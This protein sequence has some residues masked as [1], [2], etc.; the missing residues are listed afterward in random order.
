MQNCRKYDF[1]NLEFDS[2]VLSHL[3]IM[4]DAIQAV[5][6]N[7][8]W[9]KDH[10]CEKAT[11]HVE[12]VF[13]YEFYHQW[14]ILLK[15]HNIPLTLNAEISKKVRDEM[16]SKNI[17]HLFPDIVLHG[18]QSNDDTQII[19]CEIKRREGFDKQKFKGDIESLINY[20]SKHYFTE[21]PFK[22]GVF[23]LV[24]GTMDDIKHHKNEIQD[25]YIKEL[26]KK[27]VCVA[28]KG[29]DHFDF[30][31]LSVIIDE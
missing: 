30:Q 24:D 28:Y 29:K 18:G 2:K 19:A 14:S 10:L 16:D 3:C 15:Q 21:N 20:T 6:E 1:S 7:Y 22:C 8:I 27:I 11:E 9:Y 5:S 31:P 25:N 13:A 17:S 12:R 23:V 26:S 4:F